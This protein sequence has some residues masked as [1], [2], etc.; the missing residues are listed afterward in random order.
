MP[1]RIYGEQR[2]V[3]HFC[4]APVQDN[5]GPWSCRATG[6]H[7]YPPHHGGPF[8]WRGCRPTSR[9]RNPEI[10]STEGEQKSEEGCLSIPDFTDVIVRP[11]KITLCGQ[12][13][14]GVEIKIEADGLM[15]RCL[16]HAL[17][18]NPPPASV[19]IRAGVFPPTNLYYDS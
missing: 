19:P 10:V 14:H 13:I 17:D 2:K 15:A 12:D 6:G 8:R 16:S 1:E 7:Q 9:E 4:T 11:S 5:I 3:N 18:L